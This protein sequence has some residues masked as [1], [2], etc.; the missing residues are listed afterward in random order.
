[1]TNIGTEFAMNRR[2]YVRVS[3]V[4]RNE[5]FQSI[6]GIVVFLLLLIL[7]SCA[8][9]N[10]QRELTLSQQPALSN[11]K[12]EKLNDEL[13]QKNI[14]GKRPLSTADYKIGPEDLLEIT[15]FQANELNTTV[16]VSASGFIKLP[17]IDTIETTGLNVSELE[18]LICKKMQ[19]Y[20][21]EPVVS[22]F[23]K[24]YRS[25]QIAV[26]GAV[27]NPGVF[28]V[29]GQRYLLD[30][31]SMAGGLSQ[32]AGD[33]CII[34]KN[35][36]SNPGN[37]PVENVVVDLDQ[38]LMRGNIDLNMPLYSG[39]VIHVPKAGI[40]FVDGAV[41]GPGSF[42]LKGKVTLT[43]AISLAKG[44]DY[45]AT[46]SDLKIYRDNGKPEREVIEVD[47]DSILDS[48][49]PDFEIKDKDVIIVS[50]SGFKRIMKGIATGIS[51]GMFRIT[52][53][54]Y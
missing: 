9:G 1:M 38:L 44:L 37:Q 10:I 32:D 41:K 16:R 15:V 35:S 29:T 28:Y 39:Y 20:L 17:L 54:P 47:Y 43:Q 49:R 23:I 34:Q 30:L 12:T 22:V 25:Q 51:F 4:L 6:I 18:S 50:S 31:L 48:K 40:F 8:G 5:L 26:L 19:K 7:T 11:S 36:G 42:P 14:E 3:K 2:D 13:S 24:E 21:T 53:F 33:L 52:S 45:E 46:R 27:K